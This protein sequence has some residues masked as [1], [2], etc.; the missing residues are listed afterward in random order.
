[1]Y[2]GFSCAYPIFHEWI[3]H[4]P[5]ISE[6]PTSHLSAKKDCVLIFQRSVKNLY[7]RKTG[8]L[9]SRRVCIAGFLIHLKVGFHPAT[10]LLTP[11]RDEL[12]S[13][14]IHDIKFRPLKCAINRRSTVHRSNFINH[15]CRHRTTPS[16]LH[17]SFHHPIT[18]NNT[19]S[20]NNNLSLP[21]LPSPHKSQRCNFR[22]CAPSYEEYNRNLLLVCPIK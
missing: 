9:Q 16:F 4:T 14:D 19:C 12:R 21:F 17:S 2:R 6:T 11:L 10:L 20:A 3:E 18:V 7:H 13:Q 15:H 5:S 22:K 1:M 8:F